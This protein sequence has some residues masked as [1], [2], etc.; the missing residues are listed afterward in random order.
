MYKQ[1]HRKH[2]NHVVS[3]LSTHRPPSHQTSHQTDHRNTISSTKLVDPHIWI[4]VK[5][6]LIIRIWM[7]FYIKTSSLIPFQNFCVSKSNN[8]PLSVLITK[9]GCVLKKSHLMQK[10]LVKKICLK[11]SLPPY[12]LLH[13]C[14]FAIQKKWWRK[15]RTNLDSHR[16]KTFPFK[17]CLWKFRQHYAP[18]CLLPLPFTHHTSHLHQ[19]MKRDI[20]LSNIREILAEAIQTMTVQFPLSQI[21][22]FV[23]YVCRVAAPRDR[24]YALM[25][26]L[27][28]PFFFG[29]FVVF[30]FFFLLLCFSLIS[31]HGCFVLFCFALFCIVLFCY[32]LFWNSFRKRRWLT[33]TS[34]HMLKCCV[35]VASYASLVYGQE[36]NEK[37]K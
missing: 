31:T 17:I 12:F 11:K 21:F 16:E 14:T 22:F 20:H 23:F 18:S 29:F 32:V 2:T 3:S 8:N 36:T 26:S 30:F 13:L 6:S 10:N 37:Q 9:Q 15:F 27:F 35:Y 33:C 1:R 24:H 7:K 28:I 19:P 34:V 5:T 4:C 25:T